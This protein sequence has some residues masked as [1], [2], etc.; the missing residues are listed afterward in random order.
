MNKKNTKHGQRNARLYKIWCGIKYRCYNLNSNEYEI[1]GGRGI[2]LCK[3]W[4]N[5]F[6]EFYKWAIANGYKDDLTIDR[7][8][9]DG[10][11]TPE[12]CRWTTMKIQ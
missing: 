10:N 4:N 1:Y 11:Y 3:E 2:G 7:I 6:E 5:N 8:N 12:N 9:V